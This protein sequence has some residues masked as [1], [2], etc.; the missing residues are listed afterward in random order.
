MITSDEELADECERARLAGR[1]ALDTEFLWERT[2]APQ[3]CLVQLNVEGE[4]MLADPLDGISLAPV[5]DLISDPDVDVVMHAPHADMVAFA[6]GFGADPTNVFDTQLAAGFTGLSAG[7][8]YERLV[9][10]VTGERVQPSESFSD[11]SRRPLETRQL[12][13]AGEDVEHLFPMAETLWEQIC[14]L[15]RDGWAREELGRRFEGRDRYVTEPEDA[16]RRVGR[17]GKLSPAELAVLREVAA[18]REALARSRDLPVGWIVRDPSLVELA[19]RQPATADDLARVRGFDGSM[20]QR[21][22]QDLVAAIERGRA[23]DPVDD[24][25]PEPARGV[26][27]R[28]ATA[29]GLATALLRARCESRDIAPELVGTSGDVEALIAWVASGGVAGD[30]PS[31]LRGWREPFG[32]DV[33]DLVEGRVQLRLVEDEPFLDIS[34]VADA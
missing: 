19:R 25:Q 15:G 29:K 17:R 23:A 26:R 28:V 22:R 10:A 11:W 34:D 33:V 18:W 16:W 20:R 6:L 31:L 9:Q 24:A 21:D 3:I 4:T 2:Y 1:I 30:E 14:D 5:A 13:Y 32:R 27:K 7:L 8:A 12:R